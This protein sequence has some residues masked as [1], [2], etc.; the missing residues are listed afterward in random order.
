MLWPGGQV[1]TCTGAAM[2][3]AALLACDRER[4]SLEP[5]TLPW[6]LQENRVLEQ[7]SRAVDLDGDGRDELYFTY[8]P[9]GAGAGQDI[10]A[11]V[12]VSQSNGVIDQVN[13]TGR[14]GEPLFRDFDEDGIL[15]AVVPVIRN[16][17]MFLSVVGADGSKRFSLFLTSGQPRVEP[18]GVIPWDASIIALEPFD[19]EGDGTL[20]LITVVV[21][22]YARLPRGVY[23]HRL[24]GGE[25]V[26]FAG[27]GAGLRQAVIRDFDGDGHP[28]V[29]A[30]A[31]ATNN[32]A[33]LGG[34]D[35][36]RPYALLFDTWPAP[37]LRWSRELP[38]TASNS[39]FAAYDED[40]DGRQEILIL[41]NG[42]GGGLFTLWDTRTWSAVRSRTFQEPLGYAAAL[43]VDR[44]G[45]LE[46]VAPV[47][48][49]RIELF[50]PRFERI[51]SARM[52]GMPVKVDALPDLDGDGIDEIVVGWGN[53][54]SGSTFLDPELRP[55]AH[56]PDGW[57]AGVL[58]EGGSAVRGAI[59]HE[60]ARRFSPERA[61]LYSLARNRW[62]LAYRYGPSA[63]AAAASLGILLVLSVMVR[64]A[65]RRR[66][67]E[68]VSATVTNGDGVGLALID[69]RERIL[70]MNSTLGRW[71]GTDG[72]RGLDLA[73]FENGTPG[74][75]LV[76]FC[77]EGLR[78]HPPQRMRSHRPVRAGPNG[79]PGHAELEPAVTG[80]RGDPHWIVRI[81]DASADPALSADWEP[82]ARRIM[83]D[84]RNPLTSMLLT[85]QRLQREYHER[86]PEA[87]PFLDTYTQ[88]LQD[89]ADQLRRLTSGFLK[90]VGAE[91]VPVEEVDPN[92][93]ARECA[94]AIRPGLP[95]DVRLDLR[96]TEPLPRVLADREQLES[97]VEN[98]VANAVD[99]L[100]D[101]GTVTLATNL[102]RGVRIGAAE[103][104]GDCVGIEV[105]DTGRGIPPDS[106][107]HVF[108][109]GFS[110]REDG[111]GLGL[112]IVKRI[113]AAH[114][115]E[116]LVESEVGVGSAFT[117]LLP[118]CA[119][120][121]V[122]DD[123]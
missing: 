31:A 91:R 21:A 110:T 22:G 12:L 66:L 1:R 115:G 84:L 2:I 93:V 89:R 44:D 30:V 99:A 95:P 14:I 3:A 52:H 113:I 8:P 33:R 77:R 51:R 35:D 26:G 71:S 101:G 83:H 98:L 116:V 54:P 73:A 62:F 13:Y 70:W 123:V 43:D 79:P 117:I 119:A 17:S 36:S 111:F 32:G 9:Y 29:F 76:A 108:E 105:L 34:L 45:R 109:T 4:A 59:I 57:V 64:L 63:L 48:P 11:L 20:E 18:D 23:V 41:G 42:A 60:G 67:L 55:K 7:N 24:P 15:E 5:R 87:A 82:F 106:L 88:R 27:V 90:L 68:A 56:L 86:A 121:A 49:D 50:D 72:V 97:V 38:A 69:R 39:S 28:E 75:E 100:P 53:G 6:R 19:F 81:R 107:P 92:D 102:A 37:A 58:R 80:L 25:R 112:A 47:L 10:E 40:Q 96:V 74:S 114:G 65:R 122:R 85:L 16:D 94:A 103:T 61:A 78:A 46:I 104:N 118:A 120:P